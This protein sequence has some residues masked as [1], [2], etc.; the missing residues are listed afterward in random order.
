MLDTDFLRTAVILTYVAAALLLAGAYVLMA[1]VYPQR[2]LRWWALAWVGEAA[3]SISSSVALLLRRI[4]GMLPMSVTFTAIGQWGAY[5]GASLLVLG[6]WAIWTGREDL[7]V[8]ARRFILASLVVALVTTFAVPLTGATSIELRF[9]TRVV[10]PR[11]VSMVALVVAAWYV[12]RVA[13]ETRLSGYRWAWRALLGLALFRIQYVVVGIVGT[14][15]I[16]AGPASAWFAL[17]PL[18]ETLVI[19]TIGIATALAL[20]E[21]EARA[22]RVAAEQ[23]IEA[24]RLAGRSVASL[25]S[26]LSAIPDQVVVLDA[27]GKLRAWN[28][29]FEEF[30]R[31]NALGAARD[32]APFLALVPSERVPEWESQ[33]P[34]LL[35]GREL[36]FE[37]SYVPPGGDA[38]A[39]FDV[40]ARPI[41]EDETLVGAV[42]VC[43]DVTARRALEARLQ[44]TQRLDTVGRLAG[45]IAHDFNNLLTAILGSVS[46]AR[47]TIPLGHEAQSDL[48][49]VQ[50]AAERAAQLTRQLLAFARRHPVTQE[51]IDLNERVNLMERMLSRLV[52]PSVQ[53]RTRLAEGLWAVRADP[54]QL[55][56]VIV[57]LVVNARDAMP[58]GGSLSIRTENRRIED[59]D[60]PEFFPRAVPPGDYVE[61]V[62]RDTGTGM[63]ASTLAH[64]FEPFFTTKPVGQGTGLGLAMCYGIIRQQNGVIWIESEPGRGSTVHIMFP[65]WHGDVESRAEP[66]VLAP[67]PARLGNETILVVEDEPQVRAVASRTLRGAGYRVLEATN[68]R[69]GLQVARRERETIDL[70]LTDI[71]MPEM[72]GREMVELVRQFI[73]R[74]AVL[75]MSGFTAGGLPVAD[76]ERESRHFLQ[77]P[78]TPIVLLEKVRHLLDDRATTGERAL[79]LP[80]Q[81]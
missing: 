3:Y 1:R 12:R 23:R 26:A 22:A 8:P 32:G 81:A 43:R 37:S 25:V 18:F 27:Q 55:E 6:A 80:A 30:L 69:D 39:H 36:A 31:R 44:Q 70:V 17:L 65:R 56:Q 68:G 11:S 78:F 64:A 72:G 75:Y 47:E 28:A 63:D 51:A 2:Y 21:D 42:V 4:P 62:V 52:G 35:G 76:D 45:G 16:G 38:L 79:P 58:G 53:L 15:E 60:Q 29:A 5:I 66:V 48:A 19:T 41:R 9:L 61:I 14:R 40:S 59:H 73:P 49:D 77:K 34:E 71:V 13:T 33:L 10:L 54:S 50:L 7:R 74:A 67:T 20:V 46:M 24:E 57:N